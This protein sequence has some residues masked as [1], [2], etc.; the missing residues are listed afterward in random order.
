MDQT[1]G[2]LV[3]ERPV[4]VAVLLNES[5]PGVSDLGGCGCI[6]LIHWPELGGFAVGERQIRGDQLLLYR[7]NVLTQERKLLVYK[8]IGTPGRRSRPLRM[9]I[10]GDCS[11]DSKGTNC[12]ESNHTQ[13]AIHGIPLLSRRFEPHGIG[14]EAPL[15][16]DR[17][18]AYSKPPPHVPSL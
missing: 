18:P 1:V 3:R 11:R 4:G 7:S 9:S 17:P 8:C 13:Q 15:G 14:G 16:A 10:L 6:L 12:N 2:L 5:G